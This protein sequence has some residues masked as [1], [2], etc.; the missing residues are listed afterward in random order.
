MRHATRDEPM[1]RRPI[2]CV[3]ASG[4]VGTSTLAAAVA[5]RAARAVGEGGGTAPGA[6]CLIDGHCCSGGADVTL[7]AEHLPGLRWPELAD[8][9]EGFPGEALLAR[10]PAR[11]GV[12]VLASGRPADLAGWRCGPEPSHRRVIAVALGRAGAGLIVDGGLAPRPCRGADP[13]WAALRPHIVLV[14]GASA[15]GVAGSAGVAWPSGYASRGVVVSGRLAGLELAEAIADAH[16]AQPLGT[17][18]HS[19]LVVAAARRG[20]PPPDRPGTRLADLTGDLLAYCAAVEAEQ[21]V[22]SAGAR[23]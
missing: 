5:R 19:R 21:V 17:W 1:P 23:P 10:L 13:W 2:V 9:G 4:G 20:D 18:P 12:H 11:A 16:G 22:S 8:A 3:G 15:P 6:V 14:V 7:G